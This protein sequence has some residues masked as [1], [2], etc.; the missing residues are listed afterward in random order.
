MI[1]FDPLWKTLK[2]KGISQYQL[3]KK[4]GI[5]NGQLDRLRKNC[6]VSTHTINQLCVILNCELK[7]I[8]KYEKD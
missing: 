1:V 7:D 4:H 3:I 8:A 6:S 5:S 2:K